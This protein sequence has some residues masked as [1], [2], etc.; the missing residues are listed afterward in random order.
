MRDVLETVRREHR[1]SIIMTD[2]TDEIQILADRYIASGALPGKMRSDAEHI[3]TATVLRANVLVSWNFR[4]MANLW[5][6]RRYREVNRQM[7]YPALEIR[8][9]RELQNEE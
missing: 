3:A 8:S 7:G 4:H 6:I 1:E 2:A 5:R 9:P